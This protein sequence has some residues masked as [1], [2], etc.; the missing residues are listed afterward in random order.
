MLSPA[1]GRL[2]PRSGGADRVTVAAMVEIV[3]ST[4]LALD[5]TYFGAAALA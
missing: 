3:G 2:K 5:P 1:V 4:P